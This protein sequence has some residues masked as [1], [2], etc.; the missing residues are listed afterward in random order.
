MLLVSIIFQVYAG[1]C[2]HNFPPTLTGIQI[3][4]TELK[5]KICWRQFKESQ[6]FMMGRKQSSNDW[7]DCTPKVL[8]LQIDTKFSLHVFQ[9]IVNNPIEL[10]LMVPQIGFVFVVF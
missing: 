3:I 2:V 7:I 5:A 6:I 8:K 10:K 4:I 1:K 9:F